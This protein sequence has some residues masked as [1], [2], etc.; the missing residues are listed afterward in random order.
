MDT[1][2]LPAKTGRL[3][4]PY[5]REDRAALRAICADTG[6]LGQPIDPV[7][8]DRELFADYLTSYY[9]DAEPESTFVCELDG[10]VMG[11]LM[12][13]R[14]PKRKERFEASI[15]PGLVLRGAWRYLTRPYNAASRRYVRWILTQARKEVPF[16]PPD[17]PHFH[18][19]LRPAAR[20]VGATRELVDTF[21]HYLVEQGEKQV[22]GQVVT[23]ESRRGDRMFAR[24]GFRVI[25]QREVTKYRD[26]HPGKVFLFTILKDLTLNPK[27]YGTDLHHADAEEGKE[28]T[29]PE[30]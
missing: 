4:R 15:L 8:E 1:T 5:R 3:I 13:S 6:F 18:F 24:Y 19:N 12:G 9:T 23:F 26:V 22:Y 29:K 11:Y 10:E 21:L 14:F 2:P 16:T 27:L 28:S 17:I 30:A 7:F 25:D 20:S